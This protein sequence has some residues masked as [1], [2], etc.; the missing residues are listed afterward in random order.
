MLSLLSARRCIPFSSHGW[1]LSLR[2]GESV[3]SSYHGESPLIRDGP[4]TQAVHSNILT[5]LELNLVLLQQPR[6]VGISVRFDLFAS[7][8]HDLVGPVGDRLKR[9]ESDALQG[10]LPWVRK[11]RAERRSTSTNWPSSV[12]SLFL[13]K[14][15]LNSR[16]LQHRVAHKVSVLDHFYHNNVSK[17]RP[18]LKM[19][20]HS[21]RF[22]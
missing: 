9:D 22:Q 19:V 3:R 15:R 20:R 14:L 4:L 21:R 17:R 16:V 7:G 2:E 6:R 5:T 13:A 1:H 11:I 12:H 10:Q 8:F 18:D